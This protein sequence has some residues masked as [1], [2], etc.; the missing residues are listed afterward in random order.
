MIFVTE[1]CKGT[2]IIFLL[3]LRDYM[4]LI[5]KACEDSA[6]DMADA[7]GQLYDT[8]ERKGGYSEL[9]FRG[10]VSSQAEFCT[11]EAQLREFLSS[12]GVENENSEKIRFD[13]LRCSQDCLEVLKAYGIGTDGRS[14]SGSLHYE[15]KKYSFKQGEIL[16]NLNGCDYRVLSVL[17]E[18]NL[19]LM[20]QSDRQYIIALNTVMY[21]RS[22]KECP[23]S[24]DSM[25]RG[26]EWGQGVYLGNDIM[27]IDLPGIMQ[28]YGTAREI[29]T[30]DEYRDEARRQFNVYQWLSKD[31][32]LAFAVQWAA[33]QSLMGEF[34]TTDYREFE[35]SLQKGHYDLRM[36]SNEE[37][38]KEEQKEKSR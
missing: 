21:E 13:V 6:V 29:I 31:D 37:K 27:R 26:V 11:S 16:H 2:E 36:K 33:E 32:R 12:T 10:N 19:L 3:T 9:Y 7:I 24:E 35:T 30:V 4:E 17:S 5:L 38:R 20:A 1:N 22:P 18:R 34:G 14:M 8:K 23:L 15:E 25:V 28:E